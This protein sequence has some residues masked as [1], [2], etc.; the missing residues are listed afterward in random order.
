F[1]EDQ[2]RGGKS[3]FARGASGSCA[4]AKRVRQATNKMERSFRVVG[5]GIPRCISTFPWFTDY[6]AVQ[7]YAGV[8]ASMLRLLRVR[9]A[10][11]SAAFLLF[12][13]AVAAAQS[14]DASPAGSQPESLAVRTNL[15]LV[16]A[17]V[18]TSHGEVVF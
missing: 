15:V 11:V 17:L 8:E 7:A 1:H 18:K 12:S 13:F 3:I 14:G 16:P 2:A 6:M 4:G 10:T 5:F 9:F